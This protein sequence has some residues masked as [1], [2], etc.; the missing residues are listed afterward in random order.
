[1]TFGRGLSSSA[2]HYRADFLDLSH[3]MDVCGACHEASKAP[4]ANGHILHFWPNNCLLRI[5]LAGNL[6]QAVS[7]TYPCPF[8]HPD[9]P[10]CLITSATVSFLSPQRPHLDIFWDGEGMGGPSDPTQDRRPWTNSRP[11]CQ[12]WPPT[13]WAPYHEGRTLFPVEIT[14]LPRTTGP[15]PTGWLQRTPNESTDI[16]LSANI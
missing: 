9:W 2:G 11:Y 8:N 7:P 16:D 12:T 5:F 13:K 10:P 3:W 6:G 1:M 15:L 14:H 4:A